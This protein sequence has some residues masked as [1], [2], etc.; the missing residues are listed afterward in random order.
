MNKTVSL[1]VNASVLDWIVTELVADQA[2]ELYLKETEWD[3]P[4]NAENVNVPTFS[5]IF[6][7]SDSEMNLAAVRIVLVVNIQVHSLCSW[8]Q[9]FFP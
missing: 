4:P 5:V 2:K 8:S 3:V 6:I 9:R 1:D 7:A